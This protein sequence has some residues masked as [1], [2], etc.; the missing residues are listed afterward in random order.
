MEGIFIVAV[1]FFLVWLFGQFGSSSSSSYSDYGSSNMGSFRIRLQETKLGENKDGPF[2]ITIEGR[3]LIPVLSRTRLG[4]STSVFDATDG[5]WEPVFS[6]VSD[7]QE[8]ETS[9]Y[10]CLDEG[11]SV[12]YN[13]GF[14]DWARLGVVIPEL[15]TPP[16]GGKRNLIFLFRIVDFD[17]MPVINMGFHTE[18]EHPGFIW[19]EKKEYDYNFEGKGWLEEAKSRDEVRALGIKLAVSVALA[20]G[21]LDESEGYVIKDWISNILDRYDGEMR[22]D[23]KKI[24]NNSLKEAFSQAKS[25]ELSLSETIDEINEI[26]SASHKY[27]AIQLCLD[28]MAADGEADQSELELINNISDQLNLDLKEIESL[29]DETLIGIGTS[30]G[31]KTGVE[32]L[33][34]IDKEWEKDKILK[35]L[36]EEFNK[37]NSRLNSLEEGEDRNTAQEMINKIAKARKKYA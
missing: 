23:L 3:G 13:E 25:G 8:S 19:A 16:Y 37:W 28:V 34:G 30:V 22:S 2:A 32:E 27:E 18:A 33:L 11:P 35:H 9:A 29:R 17:N 4:F 10:Q 5:E 31:D 15:L 36:S 20:D 1:M 26:A 6:S 12:D 14:I 21:T 24:Y 7:F